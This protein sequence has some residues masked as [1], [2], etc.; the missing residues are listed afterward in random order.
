MGAGRTR[1]AA[2]VDAHIGARLEELRNARGLNQQQ[3][4]DRLGVTRQHVSKWEHGAP[5]SAFH[6]SRLSD[7]LQVEV[8]RFFDG[9]LMAAAGVAEADAPVRPP[10]RQARAIHR[11]LA[12]IPE[13]RHDL[14]LK[15]VQGLVAGLRREADGAP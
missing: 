4:A 14:V 2:A 3:L 15:M 11:L 1:D 6:L 12:S 9:L 13:E 8:T 10:S 7:V 5:V